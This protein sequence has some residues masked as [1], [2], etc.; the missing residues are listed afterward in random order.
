MGNMS[1]MSGLGKVALSISK[2]G[3]DKE[4]ALEGA[5]GG[6]SGGAGGGAAKG[7]GGRGGFK[8]ETVI[9]A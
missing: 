2:R 3:C 6:A 9:D 1:L 8:V 7:R 4:E 5:G